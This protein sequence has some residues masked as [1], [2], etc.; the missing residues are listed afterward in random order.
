MKIKAKNSAVSLKF[1]P[2]LMLIAAV[3]ATVLRCVQ[4]VLYIDAETGFFTGGSF[5]KYFLYGFLAIVSVAFIVV[6]YISKDASDIE[7]HTLQNKTTGILTALFSVSLFYDFIYSF[8][9]CVT[10]VN[11]VNISASSVFKAM[12]A[13]GTIPTFFRMIFAFF[14]GIY[15]LFLAKGFIKGNSKIE[16]HKILSVAP[17]AWSGFRLV[18][19]FIEQISFIRVSELLLELVSVSLM[20]MF[21][22]AF[23]QVSSGIYSDISR[24][25]ITG[26]GLSAAFLSFTVSMSR[27]ILSVISSGEYY[28]PSYPYNIT[29]I[30]FA[31]FIFS[32]ISA[33]YAESKVRA[34][35]V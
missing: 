5:M 24:W 26:F 10:S 15:F 35:H 32:F 1:L 7:Y 17:I 14:S 27:V 16:N 3:A 19:L 8:V 22:T 18:C 12:M 33:L 4:S 30:I 21:F 34:E 28:N 2:S 31:F 23:S 20:I 11:E 6:S 29:D 13:S 9:G 25:R